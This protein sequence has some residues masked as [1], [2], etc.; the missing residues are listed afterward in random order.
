MPAVEINPFA[1]GITS[2]PPSDKM[3]AV[4]QKSA[5]FSVI[6]RAKDSLAYGRIAIFFR[7]VE[8]ISLIGD[9]VLE[10]CC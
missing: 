4:V 5:K 6:K 1:T 10:S 8:H 3:D 2:I 9:F 7:R